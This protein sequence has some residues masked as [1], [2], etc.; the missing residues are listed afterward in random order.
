[1]RRVVSDTMTELKARLRA[2]ELGS[3][4]V[5][6]RPGQAQCP[7]CKEVY[8]KDPRN[9]E[10]SISGICDGCWPTEPTPVMVEEYNEEDEELKP[11]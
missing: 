10:H 9:R 2:S 11:F 5:E 4:A 8:T 3:K 6:L 7:F 1:M